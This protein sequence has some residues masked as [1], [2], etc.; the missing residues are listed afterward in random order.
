MIP[1]AGGEYLDDA[2]SRVRELDASLGEQLR[3]FA[4]AAR[5]RRPE[6][7]AVVD[8]LVDPARQNRGG[9]SAPPGGG[10]MPTLRP[11]EDA[12]RLVRLA[13]PPAGGPGARAL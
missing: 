12:G 3:A 9:D 10:P 5:Q 2:F 7:A 4:E 11:P 13:D 6:F 8:R 1:D